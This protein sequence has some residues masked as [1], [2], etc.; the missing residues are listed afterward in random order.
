MSE[1]PSDLPVSNV[2]KVIEYREHYKTQKWWCFTILAN[3]FGHDG[4]LTYLFIN[5][6]GKW[7][8][9]QKFSV[10]NEQFWESIKNAHEEL[11]PKIG[12]IK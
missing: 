11:L 10:K 6:D 3:S 7:K 12:V 8:R 2:I 5:R 1:I 4:L 9:K